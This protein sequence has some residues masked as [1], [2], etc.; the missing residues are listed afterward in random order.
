MA[1]APMLT[2]HVMLTLVGVLPRGRCMPMAP[3]DGT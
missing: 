3:E 1:H 2:R